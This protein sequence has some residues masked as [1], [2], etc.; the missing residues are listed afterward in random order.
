MKF[1]KPKKDGLVLTF[2][3]IANAE[4]LETAVKSKLGEIS[5]TAKIDG[6]RVGHA[7]SD[8]VEKKY[9]P[10]AEAQALDEIIDAGIKQI[11]EE[12]KFELAARPKVDVKKFSAK[13][14]VE[15]EMVCEVM[16][17]IENIKFEKITLEK[18][19]LVVDDAEVEETLKRVAG[20]RRTSKKLETERPAQKGD[21]VVID[22]EGF[23]DGEAFA[24]GKAQSHHL[25]L[26]SGAFIPGFEDQIIGKNSPCDLDVNVTFPKEYHKED[27]RG[28]P[29]VFK[30]KLKEIREQIVPAI[31][32]ELAKSLGQ[33]DL[34]ELKKDVA[35]TLTKTYEKAAKNKM[36][37]ELFEVLGKELDFDVPKSI[38]D[39][40]FNALWEEIE[41][42][43]AHNNLSEEDKK[44]SDDKLKTKY[45]KE[46]EKRVRLGLML[47]K[48]GKDNKIE[49]TGQD[50]MDAI[51]EEAAKYPG[52]EQ[53]VYDYYTKNEQ[54]KETLRGPVYENKITDFIF[55]Q[56][57]L[58]EK[59]VSKEELLKRE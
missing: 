28:K 14:G 29:A 58:K 35:E 21:V 20:M 55:T 51:F 26:G 25:E 43:K 3:V 48:V 33:T 31:D 27:L 18:Q 9:R 17:E 11:S 47:S 7:P 36:K 41:H 37:K 5:K 15:F 53:M 12:H 23:V 38:A 40:E 1:E 19:V 49:V 46:A 52:Q 39:R 10:N 42:A 2:K 30:V 54:A 8:V 6:F 4:E 16:P 24:G 57:K 44:L 45:T 50:L 59:K 34:A 32:D 22:F 13:E 56:T